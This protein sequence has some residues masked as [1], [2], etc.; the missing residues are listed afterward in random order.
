MNTKFVVVVIFTALVLPTVE[1]APLVPENDSNMNL[2]DNFDGDDDQVS[3][4]AQYR[5][6]NFVNV[7]V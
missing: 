7:N 3:G 1:P 6:R 2:V 4:S 5:R